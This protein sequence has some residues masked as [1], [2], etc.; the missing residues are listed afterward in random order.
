MIGNIGFNSSCFYRYSSIDIEKL[1][2][3]I[4]NKKDQAIQGI[5]GFIEG[6]IESIPTGKQTSFAANNVPSYVLVTINN[7]NFPVSLVNAFENPIVPKHN[8]SLSEVSIQKFLEYFDS[9]KKLYDLNFEKEFEFGIKVDK[10]DKKQEVSSY[11][12]FIND[13]EDYLNKTL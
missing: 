2:N 12:S 6:S 9:I 8:L 7:N 11:K 4:S 5:L 13:I 1:L 3:N 10:N